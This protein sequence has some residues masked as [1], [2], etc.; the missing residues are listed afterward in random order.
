MPNVP[1]HISPSVAIAILKAVEVTQWFL[2]EILV[3]AIVPAA[4]GER[5]HHFVCSGFDG[6][7]PDILVH[8]INY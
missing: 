1:T 8:R 6:N 5:G 2:V 4:L 3:D 7:D